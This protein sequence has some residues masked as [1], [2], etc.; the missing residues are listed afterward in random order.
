MLFIEYIFHSHSGLTTTGGHLFSQ[1]SD[2]SPHDDNN[3]SNPYFFIQYKLVVLHGIVEA[4]LA[5]KEEES[6]SA[7]VTELMSSSKLHVIIIQIR[8]I[9]NIMSIQTIPYI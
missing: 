9:P 4:G 1:A 8:L 7:S 5:F 2:R 6:S 3:D